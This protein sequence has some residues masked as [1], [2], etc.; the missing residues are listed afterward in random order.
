MGAGLLIGVAG[1]LSG[2]GLGFD[3]GGSWGSMLAKNRNELAFSPHT[4]L[5][6]AIVIALTVMSL[7]YFADYLRLRIDG[8]E[9]RL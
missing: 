5:I 6:P 9:S 8:R 7:N 3:S 1:G 2:L 4:T